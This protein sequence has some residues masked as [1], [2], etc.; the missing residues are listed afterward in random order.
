ML[1]DFCQTLDFPEQIGKNIVDHE[2]YNDK[3]YVH[4]QGRG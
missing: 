4:V 3:R 2:F 1:P